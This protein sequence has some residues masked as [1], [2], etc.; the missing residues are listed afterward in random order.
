[1]MQTPDM[2]V[3]KKTIGKFPRVKKIPTLKRET[4]DDSIV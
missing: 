2:T 4:G 1:M 3:V